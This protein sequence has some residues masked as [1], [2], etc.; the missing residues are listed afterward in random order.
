MMQKK[1]VPYIL[2]AL[3]CGG[4]VMKGANLHAR[5]A[6]VPQKEM[7]SAQQNSPISPPVSSCTV[8]REAREVRG[9]SLSGLLEPGAQIEV[10]FGY[11]ACHVPA[12]GDIVV[13][14]WAG[15]PEPIVKI[16]RGVPG[17]T[18]AL[19]NE[20]QVWRIVI[21]GSVLTT[22][23][24]IPYALGDAAHHMLS[25]YMPPTTST[26]V[27]P[28]HAYLILGNLAEGSRDSTRFGLVDISDMLGKVELV[29]RD[30]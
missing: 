28:P 5:N 25:L 14:R 21:N 12:R 11:Y 2:L 10:L 15:N 16:V 20:G 4:L 23:G 17:D 22:S 13:Y 29:L 30:N 19:K 1:V 18:L 6:V 24:G 3:I 8:T 9:N 26:T 27:I 7:I